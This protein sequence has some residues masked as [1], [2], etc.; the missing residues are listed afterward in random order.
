MDTLQGEI[1]NCVNILKDNSSEVGQ[2]YLKRTQ[3]GSLTRDENPVTH[4]C[5][6][7]LPFN[8]ANKQVFLV[9]HKKANKWISPGGH[10]DKGEHLIET[11]NREISEELGVKNFFSVI[12]HPFLITITPIKSTAVPCREHFD[13]W[14]L[15]KTDGSNFQVDPQEFY[16]TK[17]VTLTEA[18][19][20]ITDK[21]NLKAIKKIKVRI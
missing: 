20:I 10:I 18:E 19:Q 21:A 11:L 16:S 14:F 9:H 6:Y 13:I 8:P 5:V 4:F 17:W 7:F 12:P 3:E 15:L 2:R 1:I